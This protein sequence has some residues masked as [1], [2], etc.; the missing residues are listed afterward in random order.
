MKLRYKVQRTC[1]APIMLAKRPCQRARNGHFQTFE[2]A[3][4]LA[5]V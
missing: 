5:T 3:S 2:G 1:D 4:Q